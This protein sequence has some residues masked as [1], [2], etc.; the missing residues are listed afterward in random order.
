[1]WIMESYQWQWIHKCVDVGLTSSF[2]NF[3]HRYLATVITVL[4]VLTNAAVK[5]NWFL[6]YEANMRT[7]PLNAEVLDITTT[8]YLQYH[9]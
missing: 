2:N 5:E 6:R 4:D 9:S 1:M 8:D 7:Q 3:V